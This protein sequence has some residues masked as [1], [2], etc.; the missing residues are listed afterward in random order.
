MSDTKARPTGHS[1]AKSGVG[2]TIEPT[3]DGKIMVSARFK[4]NF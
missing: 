2:Y 1:L 4:P 3:T